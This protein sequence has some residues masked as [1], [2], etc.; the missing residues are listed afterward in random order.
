MYNLKIKVNNGCGDN[1][2]RPG[3]VQACANKK[4]ELRGDTRR[5]SIHMTSHTV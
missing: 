1:K 5:A 4:E 3:A 2:R